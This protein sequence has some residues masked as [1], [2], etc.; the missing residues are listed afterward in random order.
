[1]ARTGF[2]VS[3]FERGAPGPGQ[4]GSID[5]KYW[6]QVTSEPPGSSLPHRARALSRSAGKQRQLQ[7]LA[8]LFPFP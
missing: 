4:V 1:M 7:Y 2:L 8:F 6:G 3:S 5:R